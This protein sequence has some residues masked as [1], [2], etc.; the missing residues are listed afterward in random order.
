[1]KKF[2]YC[3]LSLVILQLCSCVNSAENTDEIHELDISTPKQVSLDDVFSGLDVVYM[4]AS[5]QS[6]A[7]GVNKLHLCND[8]YLIMDYHYDF[9]V[10]DKSGHFISSSKSIR[11]KGHGE[12]YISIGGTYNPY[13]QNIEIIT[14]THLKFYDMNFKYVKSVPLPTEH[15]NEKNDN[16]PLFFSEIYDL[17]DHIHVLLPNEDDR[18][19]EKNTLFVFDSEKQEIVKKISYDEDVML[20]TSIQKNP[21]QDFDE[22]TN[23]FFPTGYSKYV[24][25]FDKKNLELHK[26]LSF[27][28]GDKFYLP[29]RDNNDVRE[30][31]KDLSKTKSPKMIWLNTSYDNN[32]FFI[33]AESVDRVNFVYIVDTKTEEVCRFSY[34]NNG[35]K[36]FMRPS[37]V[38]ENI[39]YGA[40]DSE[41]ID[42]LIQAFPGKVTEINKYKAD[43][44]VNDNIA[45]LK[46]HLK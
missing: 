45:V 15:P 36:Q 40:F 22:K 20:N 14:P 21:F 44:T 37:C 33:A 16:T 26:Y 34:N 11:G 35:K 24:Y 39:M 25:K 1:M 30:I 9:F 41:Y 17:S 8:K 42:S 4:D 31:I 29:A 3:L 43:S 7:N 46:Y 2:Y 6:Y 10:F 18:C 27:N 38:S 23:L 32:R 5:I 13:S 12:I 28:Y 19:M